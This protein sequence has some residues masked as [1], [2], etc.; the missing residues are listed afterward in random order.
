MITQDTP[1]T[2]LRL[3]QT[4]NTDLAAYLGT[5]GVPL[6]EGDPFT[7]RPNPTTPTQKQALWNVMEKHPDGT[8]TAELADGFR[9]G[10]AIKPSLDVEL[11]LKQLDVSISDR[12]TAQAMQA[13]AKSIFRSFA[14]AAIETRS[15]F[16]KSIHEG[17]PFILL[18]KEGEDDVLVPKGSKQHAALA[19][20]G[21]KES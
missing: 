6:L 18:K 19:H 14:A 4:P 15:Y 16:N 7:V 17:H 10:N 5:I 21:F 12:E 2:E 8:S 9:S 20:N 13:H 1:A 11:F 3:Y